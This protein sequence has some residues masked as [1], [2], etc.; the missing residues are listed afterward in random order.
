MSY[1]YTEDGEINH[2]TLCDEL[3]PER[4]KIWGSGTHQCLSGIP[5]CYWCACK[6]TDYMID[7]KEDTQRE[8]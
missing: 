7:L 4:V 2:C 5:V 1:H 3:I 6:I 8:N